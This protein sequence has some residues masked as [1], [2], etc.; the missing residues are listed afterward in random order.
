VAKLWLLDYE[1]VLQSR[2]KEHLM[3]TTS[4][5]DLLCH[6]PHWPEAALLIQKDDDFG[7][8]VWLVFCRHSGIVSPRCLPLELVDWIAVQ[9]GH[10]AILACALAVYYQ[11][12]HV[13]RNIV[14]GN[15]TLLETCKG[16]Y[17]TCLELHTQQ[18]GQQID[19]M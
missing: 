6:A 7:A 13:Y 19:I 4:L 12:A 17:R 9:L 5:D 2:L 8:L 15:R 10:N 1:D 11:G 14:V 16:F 3:R 18:Q